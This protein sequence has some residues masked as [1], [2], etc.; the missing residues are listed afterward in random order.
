MC[1]Y[2]PAWLVYAEGG[3]KWNR[4][5]P[6]GDSS[7]TL[8]RRDSEGQGGAEEDGTSG[9]KGSGVNESSNLCCHVR[10]KA[11]ISLFSERVR[12]CVCVC[13]ESVLSRRIVWPNVHCPV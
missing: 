7:I 11:Q 3:I 12:T 5:C 4:A 10:S 8:V 13:E 2:A 1:M 9:R 6:N